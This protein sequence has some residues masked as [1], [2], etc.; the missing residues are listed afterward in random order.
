MTSFNADITAV[1]DGSTG[2]DKEE[3][4]EEAEEEVS[5]TDKQCKN[6]G[7]ASG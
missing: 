7:S 3:D 6:N 4:E 1:N 5:R 2:D